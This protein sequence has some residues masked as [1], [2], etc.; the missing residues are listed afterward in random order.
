MFF[1]G[2][3]VS[4]MKT[5]WLIVPIALILASSVLVSQ[6]AKLTATVWWGCM[7]PT[8]YV[9][10]LWKYRVRIWI[11]NNSNSN[12]SQ[13]ELNTARP[14]AFWWLGLYFFLG[15]GFILAVFS[16]Q[17]YDFKIPNAAIFGF[18]SLWW[19]KIELWGLLVCRNCR[20]SKVQLKS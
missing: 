19:I 14:L 17:V 2:V 12:M 8:L 20:A 5:I 18:F 13:D 7:L 15:G 1:P 6:E 10:A 16:S 4:A 9:L 11:G 3:C